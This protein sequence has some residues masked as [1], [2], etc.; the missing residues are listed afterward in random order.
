MTIIAVIAK[1]AKGNV[2]GNQ[3]IYLMRGARQ[4]K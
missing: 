4:S 3:S 2:I 1:G